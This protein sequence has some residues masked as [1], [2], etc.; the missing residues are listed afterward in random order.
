MMFMWHNN[1]FIFSSFAENLLETQIFQLKNIFFHPMIVH[2][3]IEVNIKV[4]TEG[5][6][7]V[8]IKKWLS[9]LFLK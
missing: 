1:L 2:V 3:F 4:S 5:F 6:F 9:R 8:I 7:A